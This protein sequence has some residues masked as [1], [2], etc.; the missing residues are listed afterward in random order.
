MKLKLLLALSL[1]CFGSMK[2][3]KAHAGNIGAGIILGDPY[4]LSFDFKLGAGSSIDAVVSFSGHG[5][6]HGTY[7]FVYPNSFG[8][9]GQ[10]LGWYWGI[11]A[12]YKFQAKYPLR[13]R[14]SIGMDIPIGKTAWDVF[15]EGALELSNAIDLDGGI[16]VRYYF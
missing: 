5:Y 7:K 10:M 12:G 3:E 13:G 6:V 11:G 15:A 4:G 8:S 2:S 14:A 9:E 16:G 1:L